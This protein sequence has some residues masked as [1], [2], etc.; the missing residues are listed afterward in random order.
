VTLRQRA[1]RVPFLRTHIRAIHSAFFMRW[2]PT[3]ASVQEKI[4]N[5]CSRNDNIYFVQIGAN[6]GIDQFTDLREKFNWSGLLLEPQKQVFTE[7]ERSIGNGQNIE[8]LNAAIANLSQDRMLHKI[9]FS[10]SRWATGLASFH[11]DVIRHHVQNGWIEKCAA[12]EG[13]KLPSHV[14]DWFSKERV[15]C[16]T[17]GELVESFN[18]KKIDILAIDTEGYDFEVIKLIDMS[19]VKPRIIVF[20]SVHLEKFVY[21][22]CVKYLRQNGYALNEDGKDV[23]ACNPWLP[24]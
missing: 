8:I 24:G 9:S 4:A 2:K 23:I 7:L 18:I 17:F 16:V 20:E 5:Y 10:N 12:E 13:I 6:N 11:E 1:M 14:D 19:A 15:R 21:K 22:A 3:P